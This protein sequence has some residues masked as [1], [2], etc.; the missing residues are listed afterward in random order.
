MDHKRYRLSVTDNGTVRNEKR[1]SGQGL[2]NMNMR[3]KRIDANV[4]IENEQ[5]FRVMVEGSLRS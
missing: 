1:K 2:R 5:G 3:A 4:N